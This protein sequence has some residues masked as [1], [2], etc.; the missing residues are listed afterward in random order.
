VLRYTGEPF[1]REGQELRWVEPEAL[2]GIGLLPADEP[3]VDALM[4]ERA[5]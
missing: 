2:G 3:I 4:V 5:R 1:A